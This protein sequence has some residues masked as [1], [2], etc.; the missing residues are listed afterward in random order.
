MKSAKYVLNS[1][2]GPLMEALED[3]EVTKLPILVC[4]HSMGGGIASILA[5][6][7]RVD[8]RVPSSVKD[9]VRAVCIASAAIGDRQLTWKLKGFCVSVVLDSD[10]VP[11]IDAGSVAAF[12]Q[13]VAKASPLKQAILSLSHCAPAYPRR[14]VL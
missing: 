10:L 6:L 2:I 13:E 3:Q 12:V 14:K 7:L 4:G 9:K 8:P 1:I 11:R 5:L